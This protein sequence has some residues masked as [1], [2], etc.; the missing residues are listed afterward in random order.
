MVRCAEHAYLALI[1]SQAYKSANLDDKSLRTLD[2]GILAGMERIKKLK[3][4][5]V[6]VLR[7]HQR[8]QKEYLTAADHSFLIDYENKLKKRDNLQRLLSQ[9]IPPSEKQTENRQALHVIQHAITK[10]ISD[11]HFFLAE[12]NS[13]F[14]ETK[15]KL[16]EPYRRKNVELVVHDILQRNL[17]VL[18]ELKKTSTDVLKHVDA[19][20][21]KFDVRETPHPSFTAKEIRDSLYQQY[22]SLNRQHEQAMAHSKDWELMSELDKDELLE[23]EIVREL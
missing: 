1:N 23:K 18:N 19:L 12:N 14:W 10:K 16:D 8:A 11:L 5:L 22:R 7:A 17:E 2:Q 3:R 15:R 9:L 21:G 13:R 6:D 20:R 4:E